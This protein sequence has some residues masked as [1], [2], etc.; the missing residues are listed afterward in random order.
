MSKSDSGLGIRVG[1]KPEFT[2]STGNL[3]E[4]G[5]ARP[6]P[7]PA[8]QQPGTW[9]T[10]R[11]LEIDHCST[12]RGSDG[13]SAPV[14]CPLR[15]IRVSSTPR[16]SHGPAVM[17]CPL[18]SNVRS[19]P[20]ESE[21]TDPRRSPYTCCGLH[22]SPPSSLSLRPGLVALLPG[23][24]DSKSRR[25]RRWNEAA[26]ATRRLQVTPCATQQRLGV[27]RGRRRLPFAIPLVLSLGARCSARPSLVAG[28]EDPP[29]APPVPC[30]VSHDSHLLLPP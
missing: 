8:V 5:P 15:P 29:L 9:I 3:K 26:D 2:G 13:L 18:R 6:G 25:R 14:K 21:Q 7:R 17:A 12:P 19:A 11:E 23:F 10:A 28:V 24:S 16:G 27:P 20:S 30:A 1:F 4:Y 22:I